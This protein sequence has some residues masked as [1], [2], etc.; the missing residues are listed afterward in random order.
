MIEVRVIPPGLSGEDLKDL[1][2]KRVAK[3]ATQ[4]E[5]AQAAL[6]RRGLRAQFERK[7]R[8]AAE[9]RKKNTVP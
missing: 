1:D 7:A 4:R 6:R 2:P 9:K 5:N 3:R 8:Q